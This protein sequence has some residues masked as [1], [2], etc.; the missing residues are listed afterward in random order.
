MA[1]RIPA[2]LIGHGNPMNALLVNSYTQRWAAIGTT[3]PRPKA[4][5]SVSAHWYIEG[6]A[7]TRE[8]GAEDHPRLRRL[9]ARTVSSAISRAR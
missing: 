7:V 9:S 4:I 6:A 1:E 3:L 8:H 5:L 2:L